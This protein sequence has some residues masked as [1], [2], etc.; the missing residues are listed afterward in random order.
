[1][2]RLWLR[3]AATSLVLVSHLA[4]AEL[5]RTCP[6]ASRA[7]VFVPA[8]VPDQAERAMEAELAVEA[9]R[10]DLDACRQVVGAPAVTARVTWDEP[11]HAAQLDVQVGA[12]VLSRQLVVGTDAEDVLELALILGDLVREAVAPTPIRAPPHRWTFGVRGA[13]DGYPAGTAWLFGADLV[14]RSHW[15]RFAIELALT[16]RT[17]PTLTV[18]QGSVFLAG[19]GGSLAALVLLVGTD[20]VRL[21]AEG[22]ALVAALAASATATEGARASPTWVATFDGRVGLSVELEL[23]PAVVTLRAGAAIPVV[24]VSARADGQNVVGI[25]GLGFFTSLGLAFSTGAAP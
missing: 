25:S 21:H 6:R 9:R 13:F 12:R 11:N 5:P 10:L 15:H 19:V 24:G 16:G 18:T 7:L 17:S 8:E 2:P 3:S 20:R 22:G 4:A 14:A 1:M 23:F